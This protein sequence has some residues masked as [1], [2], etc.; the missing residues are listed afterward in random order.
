MSSLLPPNATPQEVAVAKTMARVSDVPA[1]FDSALDPMRSPEAILPWLGWGMSVDSWGADW[2]IYVRRQTVQRSLKIHRRKGTVGALL[3]AISGIGVP[4]EIEEWHQRVPV[5]E[6][7]TFRILINSI[8]TTVTKEDIQRLLTTTDTTKNLR[9]HLTELVP[10]LSSY[11]NL[12][13]AAGSASGIER[14]VES[15]Y[16]DISLL[17]AA[18]TEGEEAVVESVSALH[19]HIHITLPAIQEATP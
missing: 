5:G 3:D 15:R 11:G 4:A 18:V 14:Q 8:S 2:P 7:Y 1:P 10:G 17:V 16:A 12:R 9:S 13:F 6:P 19:T